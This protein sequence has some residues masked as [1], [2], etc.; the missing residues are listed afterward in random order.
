MR[1]LPD[2]RS[3]PDLDYSALQTYHRGMGSIFGAQLGE[4]I[5]DS[6]LYGLFSDRELC[7][8]LFVGIPRC[9][10]SSRILPAQIVIF[11]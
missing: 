5:F 11:Q 10:R 9:D 4:N 8:N 6:A 7:S 3:E 1:T 2:S